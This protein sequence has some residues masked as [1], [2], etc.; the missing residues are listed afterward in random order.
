[1]GIK[2]GRPEAALGGL[3][4][5]RDDV[6]F[7]PRSRKFSTGAKRAVKRQHQIAQLSYLVRVEFKGSAVEIIDVLD[8][9]IE[10]ADEA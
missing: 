5:P 1:M 8:E 4:K 2:K 3:A 9:R 7:S 6:V 10:L